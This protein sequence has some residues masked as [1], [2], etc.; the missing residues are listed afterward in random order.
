MLT[1]AEQTEI[2]VLIVSSERLIATPRFLKG[3]FAALA[4]AVNHAPCMHKMKYLVTRVGVRSS[5]SR[6]YINVFKK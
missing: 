2:S 5:T 6:F 4:M 3:L 1:M